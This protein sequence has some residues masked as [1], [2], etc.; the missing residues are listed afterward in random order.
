MRHD[1]FKPLDGLRG[2]WDQEIPGNHQHTL[3]PLLPGHVPPLEWRPRTVPHAPGTDFH[4]AA[5][6]K[7]PIFLHAS[8]RARWWVTSPRWTLTLQDLSMMRRSYIHNTATYTG[9]RV[10]R[11]VLRARLVRHPARR[12]WE[13]THAAGGLPS[14]LRIALSDCGGV[15]TGNTWRGGGEQRA[16]GV[17]AVAWWCR[18]TAAA[19]QE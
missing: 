8:R 4:I 11:R 13:Q 9:R 17:P 15:R 16:A 14:Q 1:V 19:A 5:G 2:F 7:R 3:Q 18:L 10:Q 6:S 12:R